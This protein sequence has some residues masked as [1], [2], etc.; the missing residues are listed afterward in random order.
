MRADGWTRCIARSAEPTGCGF[1]AD[2][3]DLTRVQ[4]AAPDR[5]N[6]PGRP[7]IDFSACTPAANRHPAA[8]A[9]GDKAALASCPISTRSSCT[10]LK[11][12]KG[13][14]IRLYHLRPICSSVSLAGCLSMPM[15]GLSR[16]ILVKAS[17]RRPF[18]LGA[19]LHQGLLNTNLIDLVKM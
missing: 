3:P 2:E 9:D 8:A 16:I 5:G 1:D 17:Q 7:G 15:S 12:T 18:H 13:R 19:Q 14:Y 11:R 6:Y 4:F 10:R